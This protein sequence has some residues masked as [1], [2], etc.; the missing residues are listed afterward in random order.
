MSAESVQPALRRPILH[1]SA[2]VSSSSN[3]PVSG[4]SKIKPSE[5]TISSLAVISSD[6]E[7]AFKALAQSNKLVNRMPSNKEQ[8]R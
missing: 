4:F 7:L 3:G 1:G 2:T 8:N 5:P 6:Q